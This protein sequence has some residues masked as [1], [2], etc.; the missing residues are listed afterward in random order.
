MGLVF[1]W[2]AHFTCLSID[3]GYRYWLLS[4][5]D[6]IMCVSQPCALVWMICYFM[7]KYFPMFISLVEC[8]VLSALNVRMLYLFA[9]H[10]HDYLSHWQLLVVL[11]I[12]VFV[13]YHHFAAPIILCSC[14][15][16]VV[17]L[18]LQYLQFVFKYWDFVY[19]ES[20]WHLSCVVLLFGSLLWACSLADVSSI[21]QG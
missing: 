13:H 9:Y 2:L 4:F 21:F 15:L 1:I 7:L 8:F 18:G 5:Y 19:T 11:S 6:N 16:L 14:V 3:V 10:G 12:Y 17:W 20:C